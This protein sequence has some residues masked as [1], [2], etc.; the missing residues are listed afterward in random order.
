M[1]KT[2]VLVNG[3]T[4][5]ADYFPE[6]EVHTIRLQTSRW[7]LRDGKLTVFDLSI[8]KAIPVDSILWRLGAV[9]PFPNFRAVLELVR[10]AQIPCL[11]STNVLLRGMDRLSMLNELK[12]IGL[13]VVPFTVLAKI[14]GKTITGL[15]AF[16]KEINDLLP[17]MAGG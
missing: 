13:P 11:N 10:F 1:A 12:E 8:G 2:L 6:F 17:K 7:L 3:E 5:W 4:F 16:R 9:Q 14:E 15:Y